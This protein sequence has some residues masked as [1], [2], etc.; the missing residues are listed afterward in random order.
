MQR[1]KHRVSLPI[2][3]AYT[4]L[5]SFTLISC[6]YLCSCVQV[7]PCAVCSGCCSTKFYEALELLW[8]NRQMQC[9]LMTTVTFGLFSSYI[10]SYMS[11]VVI[12]NT[13][14]IDKVGY[15]SAALS[16]VAAAASPPLSY[17]SARTASHTP[18]MTLG[19]V[20]WLACAGKRLC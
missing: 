12:P 20:S 4:R 9:M 11:G 1:P 18:S 16:L 14:G 6:V 17:L 15:F 7:T 8:L 10:N 2:Y 5:S 3:E 19:L 13:L